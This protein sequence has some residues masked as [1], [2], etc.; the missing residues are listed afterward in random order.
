MLLQNE[1][2]GQQGSESGGDLVWHLMRERVTYRD[3]TRG[4]QMDGFWQQ[5]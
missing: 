1:K 5:Y 3:V 4:V 2:G